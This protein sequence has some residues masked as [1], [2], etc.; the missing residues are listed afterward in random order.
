MISISIVLRAQFYD[1]DPMGRVWHGHYARY[2]E[3][4][5]CALLDHIDYSYEQMLRSGY[6]WPIVDMQI[7]YVRPVLF[8]QSLHVTATLVE[9]E[10]RLRI[11]Y[12]IMDADSKAIITRGRTIQIAV[13][14]ASGETLFVSPQILLDKVQ[15]VLA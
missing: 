2:F 14:E 5:R 8:Q 13:E 10:N 4:A 1:L 15:K 6:L 11:D 7:K 3:E 9:W 12:Q